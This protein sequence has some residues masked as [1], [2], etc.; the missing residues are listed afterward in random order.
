MSGK[1]ISF[2]NF[3]GG[4]GKTTLS[5]NVAACLAKEYHKKVLLIDLDPQSNSSIWLLGPERWTKLNTRGSKK[6]TTLA[7]FMGNVKDDA[8]IAPF[9]TAP[10]A[11][12]YLP[13][14]HLLPATFHMVRLE[15]AILQFANKRRLDGNYREGDEYFFLSDDV[16]VLKDFDFTLIDC[17]PN[18]YFG[19]CNAV[20]YSDYLLIP[21][22]P[23]SLSTSGLRLM[24]YELANT[25][26]PLVEQDRLKKTPSVLGVAITRF[27]GTN[28]HQTGMNII[29][30]MISD[31]RTES[32]PLV[33]NK[34]I[35]FRD[36]QIREYTDHSEAVKDSL[37][38]CFYAPKTSA[39]RDIKA[40]T[41]AML[42]TIKE[43]S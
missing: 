14:L 2:I 18:L 21:C 4:V 29:E 24:I 19:T 43:R 41:D 34:T 5:V 15:A 3:K 23:D 8:F 1:I 7:M 42:S 32:N 31:F 13:D 9:D 36:Q 12:N 27:K 37:P 28:E 25:I 35:V 20:C 16:K 40:F 10:D 17:P 22:I 26:S 33:D 30:N 11:D 39:Y 38:L 6:K